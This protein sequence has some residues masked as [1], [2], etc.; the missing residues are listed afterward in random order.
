M[1]IRV[2]SFLPFI[3][4]HLILGAALAP[5]ANADECP[6]RDGFI[7][8]FQT[9][10]DKDNELLIIPESEPKI[11]KNGKL[12]G[13][14]GKK[15]VTSPFGDISWSGGGQI[16]EI[17]ATPL[18]RVFRFVETAESESTTDLKSVL[19]TSKRGSVTIFPETHLGW[20]EF[21]GGSKAGLLCEEK[22]HSQLDPP[23]GS[24]PLSD[25][26]ACRLQNGEEWPLSPRAPP[27]SKKAK[28]KKPVA[29]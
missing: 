15:H 12:Y 16:Y 28:M 18:E 26:D 1:N 4:A 22:Y 27:E 2:S 13:I 11:I 8:K 6:P 3:V 9:V 17:P 29:R 5:R 10:A 24:A 20:Y 25:D 7:C 21:D 23:K 14:I 19:K